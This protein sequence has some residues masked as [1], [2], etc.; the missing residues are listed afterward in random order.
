MKK[1]ACVLL[2]GAMLFMHGGAAF[3]IVEA[4]NVKA[5]KKASATQA[6]KTTTPNQQA[7]KPAPNAKSIELAF[8][9]D[10]PSDK[11]EQVLQTFQKVITRS[12]LPDYKANFPKDLVF[13]GDW[14]QKGAISASDKALLSRARMVIS[15]GYM[16]SVYYSEKKNKNKYVV[17]IDQYGLRDFGDKFF[18]PMQQMANDF[19]TF[20]KL[21]PDIQKAAIL[22]NESYYKTTKD[23]NTLV[24][25]KLKDKNCDINFTV[26]PV[27]SNISASL[28]KMPSDIDAV[29]VTPLYNLSTEQRAQLYQEINSRKLPSFSSVGKEDVAIGAMLGTSTFDV[30]KK[31]AEATSFSIHGVLHGNAVKNEKIPFYDD[32]IIFYNSDT[33][34]AL[35]YVPP[36]RLLNN[37][38]TL[39]NKPLA[40]YDLNALITTLDNS[41]LDMA[42]K[43]Y[44][45]SAARRSVASA[46]MRY[47]PTLRIDLGYQ[48]YNK[49]YATSY[50]DV[51]KHVGLFTV[52]MDQVLYSPDLVSNILL[53]HKKLK[54]DKAE[55]ALTKANVE[56]Q[57]ATLYID[58]LMLE[59]MI[60]V[61][62]ESVQETRENLAIARVREKTG[63]CGYEEVLRWAGEVSEAEKRLLA[64]QA[65]Y[66]NTKIQIN[67]LLNK[68]QKED[69]QFKPLT[70]SDPAFFTSDLHIIDHVRN[71]EKLGKFTDMLVD[72]VKYLSP[73]TAKLKAAIAM[74]KVEMGNYAQ[75]FFLPS[76]KL[77]LEHSTQFDRTLPYQREGNLQM[78]STYAMTG[79]MLGT[80]WLNLDKNSTRLLLAAEWKPIEG[81]HKIAEI[82]RCKS[83]LNE[84]KAYLEEVNEEIEMTVRS[85]VNRAISKYFMIEKSY[86]AMFA[87]AENYQTVKAKYLLG[88][89]PINQIADAQQLYFAAKIDSL[90]S[91]YEFFKELIW[92][93]RGLLA[94]NWT[95]APDNVKKWVEKVPDELPA[96]E[97]FSL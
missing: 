49:D 35:G 89:V 40:Q 15:L 50:S 84:L 91:Q 14:S 54:F 55:Y 63:K 96:E 73:E 60:K 66:K 5:K 79:G 51:P 11:N 57:V 92:V 94:V 26:V 70:A 7:Q 19:V 25:K 61:Q 59:N 43:K 45:I 46:Y 81:G 32:K 41:N 62:E 6:K 71:P 1:L 28:A 27:N 33:G 67:K 80:P 24:S 86:K 72:E 22:M 97:D 48:T 29:F 16:S 85:V 10:G 42:R 2:V 12:L 44:L 58:T 53:K 18:N 34:E 76:A 82:A 47:L 75:K 78:A 13:V 56:Y 64:M 21:V 93:Q 74:K 83:E 20:K 37:A 65:E 87:Q 39:S 9:F 77:S 30:D 38:V 8:V 4:S 69:F 95:K 90:N 88:E 3:A 31:L 23:W 17:T 52:A 68:N 36:L